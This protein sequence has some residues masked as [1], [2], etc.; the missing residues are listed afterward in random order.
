MSFLARMLPRLRSGPCSAAAATAPTA[1]PSF[2]LLSQTRA[3]SSSP[4]AA[5]TRKPTKIKL[6]THKGAAKRW[7]AIANGNF[8]RSKT[9]R[10]HLNSHMSPTR[11]NRLGEPAYARPIEKKLLRR[12]MPY[13]N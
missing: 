10:V 3:F 12:L 6:K 11:L 8:K 1:F 7:I 4:V 2:S 13:G 9:G 5:L